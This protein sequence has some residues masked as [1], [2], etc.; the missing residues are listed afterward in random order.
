M[1]MDAGVTITFYDSNGKKICSEKLDCYEASSDCREFALPENS[2]SVKVCFTTEYSKC[3]ECSPCNRQ[4]SDDDFDNLECEEEE[5]LPT[6][7]MRSDE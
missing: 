6:K 7:K 1:G 4:E 3:D 2:K 5:E